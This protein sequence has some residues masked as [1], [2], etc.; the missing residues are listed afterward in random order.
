MKLS[1]KRPLF[2]LIGQNELNLPIFNVGQHLVSWPIMPI[3][4]SEHL[5]EL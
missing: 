3:R 5:V 2:A 1:G 4:V